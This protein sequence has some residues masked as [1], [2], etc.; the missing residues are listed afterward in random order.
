MRVVP[1]YLILYSNSSDDEKVEKKII[2]VG[3]GGMEGIF[4]K[5]LKPPNPDSLALAYSFVW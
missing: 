5:V 3:G 4:K 1:C 2:V